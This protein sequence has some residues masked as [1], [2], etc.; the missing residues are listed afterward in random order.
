MYDRDNYGRCV[1]LSR[2]SVLNII[3]VTAR[4]GSNGLFNW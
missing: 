2:K 1:H 4:D 3:A